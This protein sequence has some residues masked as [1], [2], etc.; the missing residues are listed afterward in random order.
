MK[1]QATFSGPA[2][3][4]P[5]KSQSAFTLPEMLI[6]AT[7][8]LMLVSG[9]VGAHLFGLRM[10][11]LTQ[12]KLNTSDAARKTAGRMTDEIRNCRITRVGSVSNGVFVALLDGET[13]TGSALLINPTT[14]TANFILYFLN[15]SDQSFR[16]TTSAA[17]STT[18]LA[19]GVTNSMV[20]RAQDC[21]GNILTNNQNNRVIHLDLEFFQAQPQLPTPDYYKL[22]T[23]VT[24]RSLE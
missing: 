2:L 10:S 14:N 21:L 11:Q 8:F 17:G 16:R 23:A 19:Q 7:L 1:L 20:F 15:S 18:V 13:Q 3:S 22:E 9:V 5:G 4:A 24:K 12:T 6:S